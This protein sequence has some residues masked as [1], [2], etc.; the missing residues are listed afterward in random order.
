MKQQ[1][2]ELEELSVKSKNN[3]KSKAQIQTINP[4]FNS[5]PKT[6]KQQQPSIKNT[7]GNQV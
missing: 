2:K 5:L 3:K 4:Q 7:S 6:D 1:I